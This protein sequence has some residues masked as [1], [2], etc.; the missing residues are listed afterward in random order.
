M[1]KKWTV[2]QVADS[3]GAK[4]HA[5]SYRVREYAVPNER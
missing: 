5:I 1:L 4:S 3:L 2:E